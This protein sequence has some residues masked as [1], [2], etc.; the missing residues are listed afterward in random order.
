MRSLVGVV[1]R[2]LEGPVD[3]EDLALVL[4]V[5]AEG[6]G[7]EMPGVRVLRDLLESINEGS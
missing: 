4:E 1:R 3:R 6:P 2:G 5:K 7:V